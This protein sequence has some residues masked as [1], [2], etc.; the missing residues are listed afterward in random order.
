MPVRHLGKQR[1]EYTAD[2]FV[3]LLRE[4]NRQ[5]DKTLAEAI[6]EAVVDA[7]PEKSHIQLLSERDPVEPDN[8]NAVDVSGTIRRKRISSAK[9]DMVAAVLKVLEEHKRYLP[10]SARKIHY[11]LAQHHRPLR[12]TSKPDSRYLADNKSYENLV[13]L[14]ERISKLRIAS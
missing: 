2:Q 14:L 3:A 13:N 9:D 10:I 5:R 6:R 11:E 4:H 12:H 8:L 7:D 1:D